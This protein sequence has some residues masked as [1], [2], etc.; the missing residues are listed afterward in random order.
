MESVGLL[1]VMWF[2]MKMKGIS[3]WQ[4]M[5]NAHRSTR[6]LRV[7]FSLLSTASDFV[8]LISEGMNQT[9]QLHAHTQATDGVTKP[10]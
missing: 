2:D 1:D 10:I 6:Q 4:A 3:N 9:E 8:H 7:F 5:S